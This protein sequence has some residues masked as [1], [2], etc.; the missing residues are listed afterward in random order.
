MT[1]HISLQFHINE[2]DRSWMHCGS[3]ISNIEK[4]EKSNSPQNALKQK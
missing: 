2:S 4:W 1:V 3:K